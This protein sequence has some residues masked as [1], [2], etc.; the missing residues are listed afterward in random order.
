[1]PESIDLAISPFVFSE[2]PRY[3][4]ERYLK[5]ILRHA[6]N[7]YLDCRFPLRHFGLKV[8]TAEQIL[9]RLQSMGKS[10]Q[11]IQEDPLTDIDRCHIFFSPQSFTNK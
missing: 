4:Q 5:Q 9:T 6:K 3:R 11:I 7:G 10:P 2:S 1:M 8:W